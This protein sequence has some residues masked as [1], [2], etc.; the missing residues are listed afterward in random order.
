MDY[1]RYLV[2]SGRDPE[3]DAILKGLCLIPVLVRDAADC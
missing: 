2:P 1:R 3:P